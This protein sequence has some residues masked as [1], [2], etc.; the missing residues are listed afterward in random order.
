MLDRG[1]LLVHRS[2]NG[3]HPAANP[4]VFA[5][6]VTRSYEVGQLRD[7]LALCV[8]DPERVTWWT[9]G[10]LATNAETQAALAAAREYFSGDPKMA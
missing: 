5:L 10:A 4:G 6:W 2:V 1:R 7:R 9:R 8:G 3:K